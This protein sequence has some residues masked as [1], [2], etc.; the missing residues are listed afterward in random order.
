MGEARKKS[1]ILDA[2][3]C[4]S[5][6]PAP[7]ADADRNL[8]CTRSAHHNLNKSYHENGEWLWF[9]RVMLGKRALEIG[10]GPGSVESA[11]AG[12]PIPPRFVRAYPEGAADQVLVEARGDGHEQLSR[13]RQ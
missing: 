11:L 9:D 6:A 8:A 4:G 3:G 13:D 7:A 5:R 10:W 12:T 1:C 2:Y